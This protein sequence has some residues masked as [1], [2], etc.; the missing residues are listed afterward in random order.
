MPST[1]SSLCL[2]M[3]VGEFHYIVGEETVKAIGPSALWFLLVNIAGKRPHSPPKIVHQVIIAPV[4]PRR[5]VAQRR[6]QCHGESPPP[7]P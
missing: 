1:S 2:L 4:F 6:E 3:W 5:R 7:S